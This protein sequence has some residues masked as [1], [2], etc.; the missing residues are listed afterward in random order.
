M[1][2]VDDPHIN[3]SGCCSIYP[4]FQKVKVH[5]HDAPISMITIQKSSRSIRKVGELEVSHEYW[6]VVVVVIAIVVIAIHHSSRLSPLTNPTTFFQV[7][8]AAA[9]ATAAAADA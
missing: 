4:I 5:V 1:A 3:Q 9:T 8:D 2:T 6:C 7:D